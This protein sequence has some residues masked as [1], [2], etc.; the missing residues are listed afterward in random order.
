MENLT[1]IKINCYYKI[2]GFDKNLEYKICRR[3]CDFGITK[4]EKV[5]LKAKSLLRR[6]LLIEIRGYILSIKSSLAK[7]ILVEKW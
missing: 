4:G 1:E 2:K 7:Y 6:V 3:F 5:R